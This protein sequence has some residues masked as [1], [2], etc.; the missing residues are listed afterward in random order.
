MFLG[1]SVMHDKFIEADVRHFEGLAREDPDFMTNWP[2]MEYVTN[3]RYFVHSIYR[4]K[5]DGGY[6]EKINLGPSLKIYDREQTD[7][8]ESKKFSY[9]E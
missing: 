6:E 3:R 7:S 2:R 9:R 8:T 4:S 5:T 1:R